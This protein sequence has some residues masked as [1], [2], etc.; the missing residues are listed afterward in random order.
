MLRW[1]LVLTIIMVLIFVA[2][3]IAAW[4]MFCRPAQRALR[5]ELRGEIPTSVYPIDL[6]RVSPPSLPQRGIPK[7]IFR[8]WED[9]SWKT[10]CRKAYEHT[11]KVIPDW[12]Q[13]VYTSKQRRQFVHKVY[14]DYPDIIDAYELCNYGVME[15]DFWRYLVIY[16]YGGLYLDMKS[17]VVKPIELNLHVDKAYVSTWDGTVHKYLFGGNGEYQNYCV[18]APAKSEFLW[19]VVQQVTHNLLYL[20]DHNEE[21]DFLHLGMDSN[22]TRYKILGTT[23]P[24]VYT[25][26][27]M[28]H[29][30]LSNV[31]L[32]NLNGVVVPVFSKD[33]YNGRGKQH[34]SNSIKPV[35][36][37]N[38]STRSRI[39]YKFGIL[40]TC[41]N[42]I[43]KLIQTLNSLKI[44]LQNRNDKIL[45]LIIDDC[46]DKSVQKLLDRYKIDNVDIKTHRNEVN[47]GI[48]R[49][50]A[51]GYWYLY[52]NAQYI[53]NVDSDVLMKT[54]WLDVLLSTYFEATRSGF[55]NVL[56]T[57]FNCV[58]SCS[59][60]ITK[61]FPNFF[62]K[63]TIGGINMFFDRAT[64]A[65]VQKG[66]SALY[67]RKNY[68]WDWNIVHYF[69]K[70]NLPII[71][72]RPSVIQHIGFGGLTSSR[73]RFDIA[74][75]YFKPIIFLHFH[76][77]GGTSITQSASRK[78]KFPSHKNG[79][80]YYNN[81]LIRF[82]EFTPKKF[83]TF[84]DHVAE[85]DINFFSMEWGGFKLITNEIK[86]GLV[87][88]TC[89]RD[90]YERFIS[91]LNYDGYVDVKKYISE[92]MRIEGHIATY[93]KPNYYTRMLCGLHDQSYITLTNQHLQL[94]KTNLKQFD[95]ILLLEDPDGFNE[96]LKY[97]LKPV[98]RLNKTGVKQYL[99]SKYDFVAQNKLDYMLYEFAKQEIRRRRDI[100]K[101]LL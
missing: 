72:T 20:R 29:P 5:R 50:M 11:A 3:L 53:T 54:N 12:P 15:A 63:T 28:K 99:M 38:I 18:F 95:V 43:N 75:D 91:N 31:T 90:P 97:N 1:L 76:K 56:L 60:K 2:A 22:G 27:T 87:W 55:K 33:E 44:S 79:N 37:T 47:M 84:K 49:N 73:T 42:R 98:E 7:Q 24:F 69:N 93:N 59:H 71:S 66:V 41:F 74:E 26:I 83:K 8:T 64:Y 88:I 48:N 9:D 101:T 21:A 19:K 80:P 57:G 25:Y 36:K 62:L 85:Q 82:W 17:S 52:K 92:T 67:S 6:K 65:Y 89:L 30:E 58:D 40:L 70:H 100:Q 94:A 4:R 39:E 34:Y 81:K 32:P 35:V 96:L 51:N 86:S 61:T 13:K 78:N 10:K 68:G 46:S 16:Q 14:A 45:L 77:A 23:G